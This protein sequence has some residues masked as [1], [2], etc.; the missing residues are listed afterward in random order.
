[1][2]NTPTTAEA[3]EILYKNNVM[4]IPDIL[5]NAGG[6]AVS[7]FEWYQNMEQETWS[8]EKVFTKLEGK[9]NHAVDSVFSL[10]E[11]YNIPLRDAA[12]MLALKRIETVWREV[13]HAPTMSQ[14]LITK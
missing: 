8:K 5:A 13:W 9:M 1:M 11:E 3:D 10:S 7:Y 4:V 6:V 12:F 2:A 14:T